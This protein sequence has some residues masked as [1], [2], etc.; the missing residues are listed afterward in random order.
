MYLHYLDTSPTQKTLLLNS[1]GQR[2]VELCILPNEDDSFS[3]VAMAGETGKQPAKLKVQGPF[4][5]RDQAVAARSAIAASL[6]KVGF[7]I[8]EHSPSQWR[9]AAQR[10]IRE[11][12]LSRHQHSVDCEFDPDNVFL[13]W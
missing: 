12:R 5:F 3:L 7:S 2:C 1:V 8:D 13:D 11:L 6:L 4:Q 10:I 9:L